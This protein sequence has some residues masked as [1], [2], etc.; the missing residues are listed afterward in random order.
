MAATSNHHHH[1]G[2]DDK[3]I[4]ELDAAFIQHFSTVPGPFDNDPVAM[5]VYQRTYSRL[6]PDG[7]TKEKWYQT[8][9]RVV[10]GTYRMQQHQVRAMGLEWKI[11]KAQR[12]A[13]EMFICIFNGKFTPPGRGLWAMGSPITEYKKLYAALTNCAFVSTAYMDKHPFFPFLFLMEASMLGIGVGYD[14]LG[15]GKVSITAP[16]EDTHV[17]C[18]PDSREGWVK[19]LEYTLEMYFAGGPRYEY[20][21]SEIRKAG[22]PIKT[23]GG[24]ASGPAA[25]R[26]LLEAIDALLS[27]KVGELLTSL[28]IVD[29]MNL[30]GKCVVS[31]N[32]RRTAEIAI[33]EW[34]DKAF[35]DF[36]DYEK[37]PYRAD[38]GYCSNNSKFARVGLTAED[39]Q[40]IVPNIVQNGE[41]GL[42]FM[43][44]VREYGRMDRWEDYMSGK[45]QV[46]DPN[47][48]PDRR[49]AGCNPCGEQ[50]L[51]HGEACTLVEVFPNRCKDIEDFKRTLKFAYLYAKTVTLGTTSWHITNA[52]MTRNRRIGCSLTGVS[53]FVGRHGLGVLRQ[54]CREG[55]KTIQNYDRIYSDWLAIPRSIK[56]TTIKPSG[57]VSL[58]FAEPPGMH[59]N[60]TTRFYERRVTIAKSMASLLRA[61]SDAGYALEQ[62]LTDENSM[63][64]VFPMD[65]GEG[66]RCEAD[67]SMWEQLS[68]A[69][70]LQKYWSDNQIS[71]TFKFKPEEAESIPHAIEYFQFQ[72]K[73][74]SFLPS[75]NA[76]Y[77]Q[78]PYTSITEENYLAQ[79]ARCRPIDFSAI[80]EESRPEDFCDGDRCTR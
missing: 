21:Y 63:V 15:V 32:V 8:V 39:Y 51:E 79:K 58:L 55:Y 77:D 53:R 46:L 20:D 11:D 25:L 75:F 28:I 52:V 48:M 59:F 13:K 31:G 57:T 3:T 40:E 72:L 23:F 64:A 5:A 67:V 29:I 50:S 54:W 43:E 73:S 35:N 80:S 19:A 4:F 74:M 37:H 65:A 18:I 68:L 10:N 41:P 45:T 7:V 33:G 56:T 38:F 34:D 49:A 2:D 9:A 17:Y 62:C 22:E 60:V 66:T 42:I 69:A 61:I 14:C 71:A 30:I 36:K 16:G 76:K 26:E 78:M 1:L 44:N 6:L 70:F 12:S 24:I 47:F 27:E